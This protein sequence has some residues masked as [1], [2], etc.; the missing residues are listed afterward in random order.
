M[1]GWV[2]QGYLAYRHDFA[3]H[4]EL[5]G[6][7]VAAQLL[8]DETWPDRVSVITHRQYASVLRIRRE[9]EERGDDP[10]GPHAWQLI[11]EDSHG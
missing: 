7:T 9:V 11:L 8:A 5:T 6:S 10:N 1:S 3:E 2:T 4:V